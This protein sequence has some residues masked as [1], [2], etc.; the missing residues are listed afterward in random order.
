MG[1]ASEGRIVSSGRV[2][3]EPQAT[4]GTHQPKSKKMKNFTIIASS[5]VRIQKGKL[6]IK[7]EMSR[8]KINILG[9]CEVRWKGSGKVTLDG[10]TIIYS[11]GTKH[12]KGVAVLISKSLKGFWAVSDR[13]MM[14]KLSTKPLD[15]KIIQVYA[16]T[17]DSTEEELETFYDDIEQALKQS[18]STDIT[19][20]QGDFNA[21]L[22]EGRYEDIVG[23]FGLG[24]RN[25]RGQKLLE[26]A[27]SKDY[28]IGNTWFTQHP[29]RLATWRSPGDKYRNQ[30][31]F[32]MIKKRPCKTYPGADCD[33][34]HYPVASKLC[35]RLKKK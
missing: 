6:D 27:H 22:G 32:I 24:E 34:D 29:R 10:F 13:V 17:A 3:H 28:M 18:K 20:I 7:Q 31:D 15:L 23:P 35:L 33:S 26:R 11:G 21:K 12:E 1:A 19:I 25:D 14:I 4:S 16:P 8:L 5:N 30:L 2:S 9:L